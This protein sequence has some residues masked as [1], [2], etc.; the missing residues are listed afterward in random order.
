[1]Q[2]C[3]SSS[4]G[5]TFE[6]LTNVTFAGINNSSGP[7][8]YSDFT[9]I[10]G[11]VIPG[12]S[13]EF[14]G[15]IAQEV[16][17][18]DSEYLQI[19]IDW[20]QDEIFSA[21]ER[22]QIG[23]VCN[24]NNCTLTDMVDVPEDAVPGET[25]MRVIQSWN[26]ISTDP[27]VSGPSGFDGETEDYAI[28]VLSGE[29][30]PPNFTYTVTNDC[31]ADNYDVTALLT[32]FGTNTFITVY[33]TR[34][35]GVPVNPVTLV[36]AIE[37]QTVAILNNI[38]FGVTVSASIE[39]QNPLCNLTRNFAELICP[40]END[41]ACTAIELICGD[42]LSNQVFLGATQS[43]DDDCSGAGTGDVWFTFTADG[44]QTYNIAETVTDVVVDLWDGDACGALTP[45]QACK[46]F[47]ENFLV[48]HACTYYF[49]ISPWGTT[50]AYRVPLT[51]TP[52]D[53]MG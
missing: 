27:C 8:G 14:S 12:A 35:D 41:E 18:G 21:E 2:Y 47:Q 22:T 51:C 19:W 1:A 25:R 40:A 4:T 49:R 32:D 42:V 50:T 24:S 13:Y 39:G 37:G 11:S 5:G 28:I 43:I 52:F 34:S 44:T 38:P 9:T 3:T 16:F 53:C 15:T 7:S 10:S 33:L 48:T 6:W 45:M 36:V 30:T 31:E 20:N 29:C 26:V 17:I 46:D 23:T